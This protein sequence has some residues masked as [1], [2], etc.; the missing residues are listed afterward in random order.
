MNNNLVLLCGKSA[1]GKSASL[2]MLKDPEGVMYLNCENNKKLPFKSKFQEFTITDPTDV[3]DAIDSVQDNNKVHTI[4]IDSLTYLMD[5]FES[6][7]VLTSTNTMK[8]WGQY[9]QFMKNMMAQNVA[10]SNKNIIFI[11]HTSDIFNESEMVNETMV[12]VKGSL[13]NTGVESYFS[14]VIG[15]KKVPLKNLETYKS[16]LL[17]YNDEEQ[18]LEYKYVYQT[19][20]TKDTVNERIRSPMRMWDTQ[21]TFIDNNLQHILDR[22]HEYYDD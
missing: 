3:P 6:T 20:L 19:K 2:Q 21:E 7:K 18:L 22:L 17:S 16:D 9:A 14:T 10:N 15:C 12:K 13:M 4:V 5:M 8:A 1:T 11:A